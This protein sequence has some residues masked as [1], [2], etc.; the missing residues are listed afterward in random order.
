MWNIDDWSRLFERRA[1]DYCSRGIADRNT[2]VPS[3]LKNVMP[4]S[5][6]CVVYSHVHRTKKSQSLICRYI[7]IIYTI[8]SILVHRRIKFFSGSRT[9]DDNLN[10]IRAVLHLQVQSTS[11][12]LYIIHC[13]RETNNFVDNDVNSYSI[14]TPRW[15]AK[16]YSINFIYNEN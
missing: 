6:Y 13:G 7:C 16:K 2:R 3:T 10:I 4:S 1:A 8:L 14:E 11:V 12:I 5:Y 9:N 15:L